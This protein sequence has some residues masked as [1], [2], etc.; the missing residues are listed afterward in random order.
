MPS[1]AWTKSEEQRVL[2]IEPYEPPVVAALVEGLNLPHLVARVLATRGIRT[3]DDGMRFLYPR[4]EHLS[5]PFLLPDMEAAVN[6]VAHA[7]KSGRR[8]GLFGDYDADGVTSTALMINFLR[9]VGVRPEVYLPARS[10]GY[11]LNP[12][13]VE[14]LRDKGVSL[15]V[16][17][18][19]GSSNA[20]EIE[21][22]R[23]FGMET[24]VLDH[25]EVAEPHPHA[26]ALVNPKRKGALFPTRELAA[27]G[28]TFFFLIALRRT[29]NRQGLLKRPI[30]LK[31]QLDLVAVGT[32][33]DMVP[34]T[35]DNRVLVK[36][37]MEMMQKQPREWLRSFFRQG[38]IFSQKLD[39]YALSFI[40]IPRINAAGRVSHPMAAL[41]FLTATGEAECARLLEALN[42][43]NRQRQ[44]MEAVVIREA[45]TMMEEEPL[46]EK[47]TLVLH[48]EDWPPGV[49]GI[50]A[51]KLAESQGKPCIIFTKVDGTWKGSARSVPGLD[52]YGT[53]STISDLLVKFGGHRFACGLSV[54]EANLSRFPGAFEE[55]VRGA[56]R[57]GERVI[58]VDAA[59]EFEDLTRDLVEYIELLAPFGFG[60]P[61][62]GFLLAPRAVSVS[63]GSIKLVDRRNRIW[64]GKA[65]KRTEIPDSP[66]VK[67]IA[68]PA[69]REKMGEKFIH[70]HIREFVT[71]D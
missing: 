17:L 42:G 1:Q 53:V 64:Y 57:C 63:N 38:V 46:A 18:D 51:Q 10:E 11:G 26:L 24:V 39:G 45:L 25:H 23:G 31:R 37:G 32:V 59:I 47:Q 21:M 7:L 15:L 41:E 4:I 30:N 58:C 66:G 2:R 36:F 69:I 60:N 65:Q 5:D 52:L 49:I 68:C 27:C 29:M 54:D 34:L 12:E 71:G 44:G 16:C 33:A 20:I 3:C 55:A 43:A 8:I 56:L 9:E 61:R 6:A 22:A 35:G 28:V 62:P 40:I 50:A 13:A 48:K 70:L 67:I 14:T 19:C